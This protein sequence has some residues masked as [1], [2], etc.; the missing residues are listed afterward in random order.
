MR[1]E[2]EVGSWQ[3]PVGQLAGKGMSGVEEVGSRQ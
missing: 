1:R 2:E 3:S